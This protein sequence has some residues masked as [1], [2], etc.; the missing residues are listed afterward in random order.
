MI[1][2]EIL[3]NTGTATVQLEPEDVLLSNREDK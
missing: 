1:N 3:T 2:I